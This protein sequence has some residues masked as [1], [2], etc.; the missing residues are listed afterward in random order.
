MD[1]Y[2]PYSGRG[3]YD[4]RYKGYHGR[5]RGDIH[6]SHDGYRE[7]DYRDRDGGRGYPPYM[8]SPP[9][10][11]SDSGRP[12]RDHSPPPPPMR[13]RYRSR[14]PP[15]PPPSYRSP[16]PYR[17]RSHYPPPSYHPPYRSSGGPPYSRRPP[18]SGPIMTSSRPY[19]G[20]SGQ[21]MVASPVNDIPPPFR[22]PSGPP[23][24][25]PPLSHHH[26]SPSSPISYS[27]TPIS[28][29]PRP[30]AVI[31]PIQEKEVSE[32]NI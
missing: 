32:D 22:G 19:M 21:A 1:R 16:P 10:R 4:D 6:R 30:R 28:S 15:L 20:P 7:P 13:S 26:S 24:P 2:P 3:S 17:E 5:S 18:S 12:F 14:S 31:A 25:P 29:H 23:P 11:P 27:G 9:R 8:R